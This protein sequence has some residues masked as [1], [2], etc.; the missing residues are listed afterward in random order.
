MLPVR[1]GNRLLDHVLQLA[2]IARII[3]LFQFVDGLIGDGPQL[4]A[5]PFVVFP[6][7]SLCQHRNIVR[8]LAERRDPEIHDIQTIIE[9]LAQ[10]ALC[11]QLLRRL[12]D[13]RNDTSL[14]RDILRSADAADIVFLQNAQQLA[15]QIVRHRTDLIQQQGTPARLLKQSRAINS[16]GEAALCST[17]QDAL[18]QRLRYRRTVLRQERSVLAAAR[19]VNALRQQLLAGA[20]LTVDEHRGIVARRLLRSADQLPKR[21]VFS[22]N[23]IKRVALDAARQM[24]ARLCRRLVLAFGQL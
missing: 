13:R 2:G 17:E 21:K 1:H 12:I 5:K 8:P 19:M 7:K 15:L 20:G 4:L 3:I 10:L 16:S 9:I 11:H 23:I 14:H 6:K 22:V 24:H 18:Q